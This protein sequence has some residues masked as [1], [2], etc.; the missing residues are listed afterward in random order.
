MRYHLAFARSG[1]HVITNEVAPR[2]AALAQ[3]VEAALDAK[4][5]DDDK[6]ENIY[7]GVRV[8]PVVVWRLLLCKNKREETR[9]GKDR[10]TTMSVCFP[11][12]NSSDRVNS[13]DR[14][15]RLEEIKTDN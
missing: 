15:T 5:V 3:D 11:S 1:Q 10:E 13:S 4:Q 12:I 8:R 2:R 7:G 9:S 6:V 14:A